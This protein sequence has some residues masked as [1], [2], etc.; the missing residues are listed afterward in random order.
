MIKI[1]IIFALILSFLFTNIW[2]SA[3]N[4][5][6]ILNVKYV[7]ETTANFEFNDYSSVITNISWKVNIY[8]PSVDNAQNL[9]YSMS[10]VVSDNLLFTWAEIWKTYLFEF[11][12]NNVTSNTQHYYYYKHTN[13]QFNNIIFENQNNDVWIF[14]NIDQI[15]D[16][17]IIQTI[18]AFILI[19]ILWV[20][21]VLKSFNK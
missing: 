6:I 11:Y 8:Y 21:K 14:E 19:F 18:I 2:Y 9:I 1:K 12:D 16:I 17:F 5:T 10:W 13:S 20:I 7:D 15:R 4:P 3:N